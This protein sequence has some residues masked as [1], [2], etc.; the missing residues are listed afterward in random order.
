MG[1][2]QIRG[3]E[4]VDHNQIRNYPLAAD[5][6]GYDVTDAWQL[7]RS[8]LCGLTLPVPWNVNPDP[9]LFYVSSVVFSAASL[10][11]EISHVENGLV[12]Y[13]SVARDAHRGGRA[14]RLAC[15]GMLAGAKG[16]VAI[17]D[18]TDLDRLPQGAY[19][20]NVEATRLDPDTIRP[21]LQAVNRLVVQRGGESG[22]PLSGTVSLEAGAG[23]R[24]RVEY[25]D[26]GPVIIWDATGEEV[27]QDCI[28]DDTSA[29]PITTIN[30]LPPDSNS[31]ISIFSTKCGSI[32]PVESGIKISN[33]CSEPCCGCRETKELQDQRQV[34]ITQ[35]VTLENMVNAL[36]SQIDQLS[37]L[38]ATQ[39]AIKDCNTQ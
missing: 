26:A 9:T 6:T 18:L 27:R 12:A 35:L 25:R 21:D 7:P 5:S 22:P 8:L 39:P 38:C 14:Y 34:L 13:A 30:G 28:C 1:I 24:F 32:S 3:L 17:G 11:I 23:S 20:F 10:R 4:W 29:L 37:A 36:S 16:S 31:N 33:T 15:V 2:D 19:T